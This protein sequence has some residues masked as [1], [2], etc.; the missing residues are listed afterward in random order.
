MRRAAENGDWGRDVGALDVSEPDAHPRAARTDCSIHSRRP[1]TRCWPRCVI[2][3]MQELFVLRWCWRTGASFGKPSS[4]HGRPFG[5]PFLRMA[6]AACLTCAFG[7]ALSGPHPSYLCSPICS[8][9]RSWCIVHTL[10]EWL[11]LVLLCAARLACA[12]PALPTL[13]SL[14][15]AWVRARYTTGFACLRGTE[16]QHGAFVR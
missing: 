2:R 8:H 16:S 14:R 13:C 11:S 9:R 10:H 5:A 4:H 15:C 3:R 7:M 12:A 1:P 6:V